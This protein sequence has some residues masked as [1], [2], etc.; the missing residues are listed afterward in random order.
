MLDIYNQF[1]DIKSFEISF[2]DKYK[3]IQTLFCSVKSIESSNIVVDVNRK[4]NRNI[5]ASEGDELKLHIYTEGGVYSAASVVLEANQGVINTE[6]VISYPA[7]SK[8][9]QR[10]EYFRA[11]MAIDAKIAVLTDAAHSQD[12][13]IDVKTKNICGKGMSYVSDLPFLEHDA[14]GIS[15]LFKDKTIDTFAK[16][17]YTRELLVN[18]QTRYV[19]AFSFKT[20]SQ[21]DTDYIV[22]QCFLHQLELRKKQAF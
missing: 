5:T 4:Q 16:L 11:E 9:Y 14:I 18:Y 22:K 2:T 12:F 3:E 1:K 8:H 13:I 7:N 20:I 15:L 6:Y 19:H 17:V 21:K 10:R